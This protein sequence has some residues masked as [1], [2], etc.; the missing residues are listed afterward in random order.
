MVTAAASSGRALE[1]LKELLEELERD[2]LN[3]PGAMMTPNLSGNHRPE[4]ETRPA[5]DRVASAGNSDG[6]L[7]L[8]SG[9]RRILTSLAEY[10]EGRSKV[11]VAVLTGY[12]ATGGGFNN[13]LG[14][15]SRG[16]IEGDGER[17]T[18]TATG[19]QALGY[20]SRSPQVRR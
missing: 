5:R 3:P 11:Q 20:G 2:L 10:P 1:Q 13:Y 19:I 9:E 15:R 8:S 6:P 16:L 4:R 7:K 14:L 17:L 12:A 18:I